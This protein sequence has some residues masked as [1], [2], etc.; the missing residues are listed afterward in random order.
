MSRHE[1][2]FSAPP[3]PQNDTISIVRSLRHSGVILL[4]TPIPSY[5]LQTRFW[6]LVL[7][8]LA[9]FSDLRSTTS[10]SCS[11]LDSSTLR[12]T[13]RVRFA[14]GSPQRRP[15]NPPPN[16]GHARFKITV[17]RRIKQPMDCK[18][19]AV[20]SVSDQAWSSQ[21][22][23]LSLHALSTSAMKNRS[24]CLI[25]FTGMLASGLDGVNPLCNLPI[26]R[27]H[28][29]PPTTLCRAP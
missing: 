28:T 16:Q 24:A 21:L 25:G 20:S 4:W 23:H 11:P 29:T 15:L 19:K 12:N 2:T 1:S 18:A 5:S 14:R 7:G 26:L 3:S 10:R 17:S 13:A 9:T 27:L 6:C 22:K 8:Q